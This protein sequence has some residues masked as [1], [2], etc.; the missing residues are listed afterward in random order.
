MFTN[1]FSFTA[2]EEFEELCFEYGLE[3]DE[4]VRIKIHFWCRTKE[5]C[6]EYGLELEELVRIKIGLGCRTKEL[7]IMHTPQRKY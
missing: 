2:D 4:V 1:T 3:L 6:F 5:L 7:Q